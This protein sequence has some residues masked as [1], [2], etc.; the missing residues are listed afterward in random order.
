[1]ARILVA[2][3]TPGA[4]ATTVAVGLAHRLAYA[5][6]DVR[7]E[8][9]AGDERAAADAA[10][11]ATLEFCSSSGVPVDA[12]SV[13]DGG[14]V[15]IEAPAGVE[16]AAALASRLGAK[17]VAVD[18][19]RG[20][21]SG[22][23]LTITNRARK[24]DARTLPED[25]LLAAP[26]VGQIAETAH[27]RVLVRSQEGDRAVIEHIV[28][29]AIS[30]DSADTYFGRFPRKAVVCRAEKTD[31]GLAALLTGAEVLVLSGGNDPSP[32]LLDRAGASRA[33]TVL[34]TPEGTVET[35]RDIEG[36]YGT[37]PFSHA[38]K[39]ERAGELIAA[40]LDDATL[41]SLLA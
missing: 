40:A 8:R 36:L 13:P 34:L 21:P 24:G 25:R 29:G 33:T 35:V 16:D 11:F 9:L 28:I 3:S 22:A 17:L 12:A 6:R 39:V 41:A 26:T 2:A 38:A 23:A 1:M 31:L 4:G 30:H 14:V 20:A 19:G 37:A 15:V 18:G 10:V 32:Y 5:G 7:I 27:A